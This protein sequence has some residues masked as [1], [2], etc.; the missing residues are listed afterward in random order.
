MISEILGQEPTVLLD[1]PESECD[2]EVPNLDRSGLITQREFMFQMSEM[3][4]LIRSV[5]SEIVSEVRQL[6]REEHTCVKD[7]YAKESP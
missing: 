1:M 5:K 7:T 2:Q 4:E 6:L 3:M